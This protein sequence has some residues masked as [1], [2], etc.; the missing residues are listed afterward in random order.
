MGCTNENLYKKKQKDRRH[1]KQV[2]EW[3]ILRK[4]WGNEELVRIGDVKRVGSCKEG[5]PETLRRE[6]RGDIEL[7][8]RWI[9][10]VQE[11]LP[12]G[13]GKEGS[14]KKKSKHKRKESGNTPSKT[15]RGRRVG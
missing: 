8:K 14:M 2:E 10:S 15:T 11:G 5:S 9:G 6:F 1:G 7:G 12:K 13:G 3:V 4:S